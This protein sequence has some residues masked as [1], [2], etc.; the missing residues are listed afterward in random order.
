MVSAFILRAGEFPMGIKIVVKDPV[1]RVDAQAY[2]QI[3]E[4]FVHL[5]SSTKPRA[6][7]IFLHIRH[8][9]SPLLQLLDITC[10][11]DDTLINARFLLV[12]GVSTISREIVEHLDLR[13]AKGLTNVGLGLPGSVVADVKVNWAALTDLTLHR[14]MRVPATLGVLRKCINLVR[15]KIE[16]E[17]GSSSL[18][19]PPTNLPAP[20]TLLHLTD[21]VIS[22]LQ[23]RED[24]PS[25]LVLPSLRALDIRDGVET[26]NDFYGQPPPDTS[27]PEWIRLHGANLGQLTFSYGRLS[28]P[29]L[30]ACLGNAPNVRML[31]IRPP[32][33]T[34]IR[35]L[36][37]LFGQATLIS[38]PLRALSAMTARFGEAGERLAQPCLCP[39]LEGVMIY[40][41][42]DRI[43]AEHWVNFVAS[44]RRENQAVVSYIKAVNVGVLAMDPSS[45]GFVN[46]TR[47]TVLDSLRARGVSVDSVMLHVQRGR[48][49]SD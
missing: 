48:L 34:A 7:E 10:H 20:T 47:T 6:V 41:P 23:P 12:P 3:V 29:T 39:T 21:M 46:R 25:P 13:S 32:L 11:S 38:F 17:P 49:Q 1:A 35:Q 2:T 26:F 40:G 36:P 43:E 5:L 27:L 22:G 30:L 14:G 37:F 33:V 31:E 42:G 28:S 15:C 16:L 18:L 4:P 9:A 44:R 19:T 45:V 24:F 8:E